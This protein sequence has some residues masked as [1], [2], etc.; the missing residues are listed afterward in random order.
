LIIHHA[1]ASAW[2]GARSCIVIGVIHATAPIAAISI[3]SARRD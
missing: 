3:P 2:R 1:L